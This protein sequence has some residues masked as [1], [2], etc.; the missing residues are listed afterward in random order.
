MS[1][2]INKIKTSRHV[3]DHHAKMAQ[4]KWV[5][6]FDSGHKRSYFYHEDT[7]ASVWERPDEPVKQECDSLTIHASIVMQS[8]LRR[9]AARRDATQRARDAAA[10]TE[11]GDALAYAS[12]RLK[13][14]KSVAPPSIPCTPR[15]YGRARSRTA[16]LCGACDWPQKNGRSRGPAGEEYRAGHRA[17][18]LG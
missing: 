10:V 2:L 4:V 9:L 12:D 15:G 6:C 1:L 8:F 16:Q 5:E 13:D 17:G 11:N 7:G 14:D 18:A 3:D